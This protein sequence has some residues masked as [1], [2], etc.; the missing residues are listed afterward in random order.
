MP[1]CIITCGLA[2][3]STSHALWRVTPALLPGKGIARKRSDEEAEG[4]NASTRNVNRRRRSQTAQ[5]CGTPVSLQVA[6]RI[7]RQ[8]CVCVLC[9]TLLSLTVLARQIMIDHAVLP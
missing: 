6:S 4:M 3:G 5:A 8:R 7:D 2:L 9:N 1:P